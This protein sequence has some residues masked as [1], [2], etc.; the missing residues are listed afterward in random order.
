MMTYPF[1][2]F[3]SFLSSLGL[4]RLEPWAIRARNATCVSKNDMICPACSYQGQAI[5]LPNSI[6]YKPTGWRQFDIG[7]Q[8]ARIVTLVWCLIGLVGFCALQVLNIEVPA[9][10]AKFLLYCYAV[11]SH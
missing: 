1:H 5:V 4:Q 10:A 2:W 3:V 8:V 7:F 6:D 11:L 9:L